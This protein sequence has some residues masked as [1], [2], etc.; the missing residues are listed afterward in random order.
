M[1]IHFE[2]S[3]IKEKRKLYKVKFVFYIY[4]KN[5]R[6]ITVYFKFNNL[7]KKNAKNPCKYFCFVLKYQCCWR[8]ATFPNARTSNLGGK[9]E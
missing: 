6:I 1:L 7:D 2:T 3:S 4:F 8:S 9:Y 5:I